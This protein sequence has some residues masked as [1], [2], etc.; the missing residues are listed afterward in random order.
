M[1]EGQNKQTNSNNRLGDLQN[2]DDYM[3]HTSETVER[4][5]VLIQL[6]AYNA[7]DDLWTYSELKLY[8]FD[9][10]ISDNGHTFLHVE[11]RKGLHSIPLSHIS[12]LEVE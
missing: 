7:I 9:R 2:R 12:Y 3:G 1:Y 11:D 4:F 5:P 10:S 8:L 6:R